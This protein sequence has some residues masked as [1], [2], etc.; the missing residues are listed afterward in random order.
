MM[1]QCGAHHPFQ[2]GIWP[3]ANNGQIVDPCIAVE[4]YLKLRRADL[5][6]SAVLHAFETHLCYI[7]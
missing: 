6:P 2:T 5:K 1:G 3:L 4:D 7:G